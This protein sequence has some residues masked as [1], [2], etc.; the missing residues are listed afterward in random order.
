MSKTE[1]LPK[2]FLFSM[3]F[4]MLLQLRRLIAVPLI[5]NV[6]VHQDA[7]AWLYPAIIDVVV[8]V[9]TL[10][11]I[12]FL[13]QRPLP[14]VWLACW[15]YFVVSI[16]DHG[17]AITATLFSGTPSVFQRMFDMPASDSLSARIQG[18]LMGPGVQSLIDIVFIVWLLR[19]T[20]REGFGI[21][22]SA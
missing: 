4:W 15:T 5:Q 21:K 20:I 13:W 2:V 19:R 7:D 22:L 10:P 11:L 1:H 14:A 3:T 9:A 6:L 17:G 12:W 8:A 16:F 18:L